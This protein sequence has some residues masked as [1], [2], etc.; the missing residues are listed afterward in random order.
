MPPICAGLRNRQQQGSFL[1]TCKPHLKKNTS[2][3]DVQSLITGSCARKSPATKYKR[4]RPLA[5]RTYK[6]RRDCV[7][8]DFM[9]SFTRSL[10]LAPS[11]LISTLIG[12]GDVRQTWSY[13]MEYRRAAK[14]QTWHFCRN[15]SHWPSDSFNIIVS[16]KL[17]PDFEL[18]IEC[19]ALRDQEQRCNPRPPRD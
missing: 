2:Q 17:P 5:D 13:V 12:L 7:R 3:H 18:C 10:R 15:C 11:L 8:A 19:V 4:A 1:T 16:K 6:V 9:N 14:S